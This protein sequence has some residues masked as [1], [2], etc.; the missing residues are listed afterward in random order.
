MR[1]AIIGCG[2]M[3]S[4]YVNLL[5]QQ[6]G[7]SPADIIVYD[8]D[9]EKLDA[10]VKMYGVTKADQ[11]PK[12]SEAA[13]VA[14]NT[15]SHTSVIEQLADSVPYILC[16]K[17][18]GLSQ[19]DVE[20][21]WNVAKETR[22]LTAFVINFSG[23]LTSLRG[24]MARESLR[25]LEL[26][27]NWGK[28]RLLDK[29]A[30]PSAGDVEDEAVHPISFAL[31]LIPDEVTRV[32]V[33][34]KVGRLAFVDP[35]IQEHAYRQDRSFPALP[36]HS[37]SAQLIAQTGSYEVPIDVRS[38]FLLAKQVR[39]VGGVLGTSSLKPVYAFEVTFDND[40]A[41]ELTLTDFDKRSSSTQIFPVNK[42][43][44]LTEAFVASVRTGEIDC[45]LARIEQAEM[46]VQISDAILLSDQKDGQK[47]KVRF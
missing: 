29:S 12:T 37:T 44:K 42:L 23:T 34:A 22:V 38:S 6:L 25:P 24:L 45:R 31:E 18:L 40:G 3:G 36:N 16:E 46:L 20:K 17:P 28:P 4:Y 14:T 10:F 13:I 21:I 33:T 39:Q 1:I 5:I 47:I 41:D 35:I 27:G 7:F 19:R 8:I 2:Q 15:P 9:R 32:N 26:Y 11:L 30:R 43:A